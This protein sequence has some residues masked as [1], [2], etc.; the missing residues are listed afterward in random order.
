[1]TNLSK[2]LSRLSGFFSNRKGLLIFIGLGFVILN[3]VISLFFNTW[4]TQTNLLLHLGIV[5]GFLGI[6]IAWAL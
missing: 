1:M 4:M 5:I 2:L 3:F 6:L